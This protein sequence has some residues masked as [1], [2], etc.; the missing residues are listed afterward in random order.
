MKR[1]LLDTSVAGDYLTGRRAIDDHVGELTRAGHSV[2][3]CTPVIGE[4]VAGILGSNLID[5]RIAMLNR[6]LKLIRI[7]PYEIDTAYEFGRIWSELKRIGRPMQQIDVQIAAVAM[8]LR[9]CTVLTKDR[10]LL[11][12]PGLDVELWPLP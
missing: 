2:G 6:R 12:V 4:L 3:T 8:T 11:A 1:Y 7:W 10:D 5:R 9:R